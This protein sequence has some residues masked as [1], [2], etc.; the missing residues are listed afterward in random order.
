MI[1]SLKRKKW[2]D[3]F[4]FEGNP[5]EVVDEYKYLGIEFHYRLSWEAC[6]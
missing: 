6:R 4:L 3:T 2:Q 1:F 5:L